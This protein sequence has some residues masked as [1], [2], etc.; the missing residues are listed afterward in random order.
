M[1][2]QVKVIHVHTAHAQTLFTHYSHNNPQICA[3]TDST[4][5]KPVGST[6]F[7]QLSLQRPLF[8]READIITLCIV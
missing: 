3:R 1:H 6:I 7:P 2:I 8:L 4:P 5:R